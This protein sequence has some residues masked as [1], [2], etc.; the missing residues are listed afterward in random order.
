M[1]TVKLDITCKTDLYETL[2]RRSHPKNGTPKENIALTYS[3]K[4]NRWKSFIVGRFVKIHGN[5]R[6]PNQ[7]V[8]LIKKH[9]KLNL[10]L[11]SVRSQYDIPSSENIEVISVEDGF[12]R[13]VGLGA[14]YTVP[15]S[16]VF[17]KK[18]IYFDSSKPSDLEDLLK[19][20][21]LQTEEAYV[22]GERILNL[23]KFYRVNKYNLNAPSWHRKTNKK[24]IVV[25]GQVEN[26]KS[27]L[28][29]SPVIK[30]NLSLL[31]QVRAKNPDAYIVFKVHP[32][33]ASNL[34]R[35]NTKIKPYLEYANE[36]VSDVCSFSLIRQA[37]EI[38]TISSLF[39][40]EALLYNKKV[41]CWGQPFYSGWG[42]TEDIYPVERRQGYKL[43]L[44]FMV[45]VVYALYPMYVSYSG[46]KINVFRAITE[47]NDIK[48]KTTYAS[49]K[50]AWQYRVSNIFLTTFKKLFCGILNKA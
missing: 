40:F 34:R 38:H 19:R 5:I 30:D 7:L 42:L 33:V 29:G 28:Y 45:Y 18:G 32:D 39:G 13:S 25:P 47:I 11:W 49:L 1:S 14:K 16:L 27:I 4:F 17:D 37:D 20:K 21:D 41:V 23:L 48:T 12:I 9:R 44:A 31:K 15:I 10:L 2:L 36:V 3:Y 22:L 50:I 26:D 35:G 24:V 43:D 8:K 46:E 6:S